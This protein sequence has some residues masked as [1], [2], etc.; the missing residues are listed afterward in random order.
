MA[1]LDQEDVTLGAQ[2]QRVCGVLYAVRARRARRD[3]HCRW[4]WR[5]RRR[6]GAMMPCRGD[7]DEQG[8]RDAAQGRYPCPLFPAPRAVHGATW[9]NQVQTQTEERV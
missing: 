8:K 9:R 2:E 6:H 3:C 4:H 1:I 5:R 7:D